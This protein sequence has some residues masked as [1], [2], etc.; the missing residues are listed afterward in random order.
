VHFS[1]RK[2]EDAFLD[3]HGETEGFCGRATIR[4]VRGSA[5]FF[6]SRASGSRRSRRGEDEGKEEAPL[7]KNPTVKNANDDSV[8]SIIESHW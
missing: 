6:D 5:W 2:R 4:F 8:T 1:A 3:V 7:L